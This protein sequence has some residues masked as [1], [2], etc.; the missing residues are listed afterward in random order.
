MTASWPD[1][2]FFAEIVTTEIVSEWRRGYSDA[3]VMSGGPFL[4]NVRRA[5]LALSAERFLK[6]VVTG[7][8]DASESRL[9][10]LP[11]QWHIA[12]VPPPV[13]AVWPQTAPPT[14]GLRP[15]LRV[16]MSEQWDD[17]TGEERRRILAE[18]PFRFG[19]PEDF[20]LPSPL[21]VAYV[22]RLASNSYLVMESPALPAYEAS[23]T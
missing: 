19:A 9:L 12:A 4:A 16:Q 6:A 11:R 22:R 14:K 10:H 5:L 3:R 2:A 13:R 15:V 17:R 20:T 8:V 7:F 18:L 1:V 23:R 21:A